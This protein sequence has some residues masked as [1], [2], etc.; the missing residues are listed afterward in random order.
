MAYS[1]NPLLPK[2]R[3][4]TV[5]LVLK[6]GLSVS[7]AALRAGVNRSTVYRWLQKA[8][9]LDS[10]AYISTVSSRPHRHPCQLAQ[11]IVE[12]IVSLR[13]QY[14]RCAGYIH[15]L[16]A[17]EG[18]R[19]S[20]ASIGRVLHR[21]KLVSSWYGQP[22]KQRRQRMP[23]PKVKAPGS[24]LQLDTI[25]FADWK[26]KQRY[27]VYTL[28]D[29]KTR[30]AYAAYSHRISPLE[31]SQFVTAAQRAAPFG[32]ELIQ[33]DNGQEFSTQFEHQLTKM[34]IQQRRIRLGRKNDNA[35]IERFNRTLKEEALGRWPTPSSIPGK[36]KE[37]LE[38]Y[39]T[40]RLHSSLQYRTPMEI[41][42]KVLS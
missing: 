40:S 20:V 18:I 10:R 22:G 23:R 28:V 34:G 12:R 11:R 31:S 19:V 15:A 29:L 13:E 38:F 27:F 14:N 26:T 8:Q 5:N 4:L 17:R 21:L 32:F 42:A 25:H 6:E 9:G 39:N 2:A 35:H 30:W 24:F 41:V 37:Y 16:L 7:S 1:N 33:T 3:R 36:L